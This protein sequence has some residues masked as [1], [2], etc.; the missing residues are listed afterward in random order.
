MDLV[1]ELNGIGFTESEAKVY[2][3]LLRNNPATGYQ[4]SKVSGVPRS[5]VYEALSRLDAR[6][7]VLKSA[8][9]KATLYRPLPPE[10]LLESV[11]MEHHRKMQALSSGLSRIYEVGSGD[12]LWTIMGET[13]VIS[14]AADMIQ[15]AQAELMLVL[16]D[17]GLRELQD[18]VQ[19]A[20]DR[21]VRV[22]SLLTGDLELG[23]GEVA[24]HPPHESE[25][26]ELTDNIVVVADEQEAL[27]A[28]GDKEISA[29]VTTNRNL[30]LITRQ[31]IWME[32]FAQRIY[33]H[34]DKDL[35][36]IL[37]PE[38]QRLINGF[39]PVRGKRLD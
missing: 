29:T 31:F 17:Q 26:Q 37:N 7:A 10:A 22:S 14:Y 12:L 36:A 18:V 13:S 8:E 38:D 28:S 35:I 23:C 24:H 2:L 15:S 25:L 32:L 34:L 20:N 19:A 5:M 21:G 39:T 27:I 30:V 33:S 4:L 16:S 3:V 6:G 11:D 1:P 9:A